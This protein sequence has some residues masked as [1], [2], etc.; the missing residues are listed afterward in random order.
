MSD[1]VV[2]TEETIRY[3]MF[4]E[5]VTRGLLA[6]LGKVVDTRCTLRTLFHVYR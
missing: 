4:D 5:H 2:A 1:E 6:E 3:A